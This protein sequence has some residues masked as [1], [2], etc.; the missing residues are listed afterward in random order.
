MDRNELIARA[1]ANHEARLKELAER[2]QAQQKAHITS[3]AIQAARSAALSIHH[4]GVGATV[5]VQHNLVRQDRGFVPT[6][7]GFTYNERQLDAI[8]LAMRGKSFCLIGAAGTGK[9]TTTREVIGQLTRLPHIY[10]LK[11]N[12]KWLIKDTPAIVICG[13]TNKAVNNIKKHLP[14]ELRRH[15]ITIHKLLEFEP[16]RDPLTGKI[17]GFG[18]QRN[19]ENPLPP[20][21]AMIW[22]ESSMIGTDLH[23]LV[24]DALPLGCVPQDIFLG[25]L[26]QLPPIF[27]PSILGFKLL[28]LPAVELTEVYRQALESPI[29]EYAHRMREG[30]GL[31]AQLDRNSDALVVDKG[32]HGKLT[33]KP[34]KKKLETQAGTA[35]I[36]TF[37]K[38]AIDSG[39]YNPDEDIILCPFNKSFGTLEI[40]KH[41]AQKL[42]QQ[43][44]A[45]V[46][47]ILA[48]GTYHYFSV[49]DKV[50]YDRQEA[51]VVDIYRNTGYSGRPVRD[52]SEYLDR[53]GAMRYPDGH[54][55]TVAT[56]QEEESSSAEIDDI[57]DGVVGDDEE[58][59][60]NLASHTIKLRMIDADTE[61]SVNT[62]GEMNKMVFAYA[63]TVHKSQ[64]SEWPRVFIALHW[65]HNSMLSRELMYTAMTR[66]K[67]ELF[68]IMEPGEKGTMDQFTRASQNPEIKGVTLQEKAEY[69]RSIKKAFKG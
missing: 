60:K 52:A 54:I 63:I 42:G 38:S 7:Q 9:T 61:V 58:V 22:E 28:D 49:G 65:S 12:T 62:A 24:M 8:E 56:V 43:R 50:L 66:A 30:K 13:Y 37:F 33:I 5:T 3:D 34:W 25:D 40:N 44:G 39:H 4:A 46:H 41:I 15:C 51:V 27:G 57:L 14:P 17:E 11:E 32:K 16:I 1:R 69:F 67:Q 19:R 47:E 31:G 29:I 48:R 59:Q 55:E 23:S 6:I 45:P 10:P 21:A 18:P 35:T 53:W 2:Q 20:I 68:I 26:N 64:G 36:C